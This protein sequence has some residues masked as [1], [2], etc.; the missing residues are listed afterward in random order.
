MGS[1]TKRLLAATFL[2]AIAAVSNLAFVITKLPTIHWASLTGGLV[3]GTIA[4][5]AGMLL[6]ARPLPPPR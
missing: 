4:V 5:Y 6:R 2:T 1:S 3:A